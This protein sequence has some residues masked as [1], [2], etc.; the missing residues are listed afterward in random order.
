MP[1]RNAC[2]ILDQKGKP[3]LYSKTTNNVPGIS[4]SYQNLQR[5]V[6]EL[7]M[8][9]VREWVQELAREWVLEWVLE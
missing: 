6:Q 1:H 5:L 9:L 8:E 4:L 7:T 3:S 2:K